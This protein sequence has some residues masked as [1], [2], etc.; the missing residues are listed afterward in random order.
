MSFADLSEGIADLFA[1]AS[2]A[3]ERYA[4]TSL[5][6]GGA[7]ATDGDL[8]GRLAAKARYWLETLALRDMRPRYQID[9]A[10]ALPPT[11]AVAAVREFWRGAMLF[12][13]GTRWTK[14]EERELLLL[15]IGEELA[16]DEIAERLGRSR[17]ACVT[18]YSD[19][20]TRMGLVVHRRGARH[21]G[22]RR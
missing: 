15:A 18:R 10:P 6:F 21:P 17:S 3:G 5:A 1:E 20:K 8:A 13:N 4:S 11:R 19:L 7:L 9:P 22:A 16:W 12:P 14:E 2:M